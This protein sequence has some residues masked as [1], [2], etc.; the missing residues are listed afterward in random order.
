[1]EE[2]L[3]YSGGKRKVPVIVVDGEASVGFRGA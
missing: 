3:R 2:M 1:M